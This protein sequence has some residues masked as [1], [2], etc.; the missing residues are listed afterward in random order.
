MYAQRQHVASWGCV[1][2]TIQRP[3]PHHQKPSPLGGR[4]RTG[5]FIASPA[6]KDAVW[7]LR[8]SPNCRLCV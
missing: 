4:E 3:V 5:L 6:C 8:H 7:A 2:L 1:G